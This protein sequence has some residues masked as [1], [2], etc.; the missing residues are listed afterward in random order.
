[1]GR[2]KQIYIIIILSYRIA[3]ILENSTTP[4]VYYLIRNNQ[5]N[6]NICII[7]SCSRLLQ[8]YAYPYKWCARVCTC[9]SVYYVYDLSIII[10]YALKS[11]TC[12][13]CLCELRTHR[14]Y[15]QRG[16][17]PVA[18]ACVWTVLHRLS[19][20]EEKNLFNMI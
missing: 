7:L 18:I 10:S 17:R 14:R 2:W 4:T 8:W 20:S 3:Y 19:V 9:L 5:K 13:L 6:K 1:M 15:G 16:R 12:E 11:R